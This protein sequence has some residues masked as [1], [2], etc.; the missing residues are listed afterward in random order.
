MTMLS[1]PVLPAARGP[2]SATVAA[3]LSAPPTGRPLV[4]DALA[5]AQPFGN[6]LQLALH[7]CYE[8]HYQ[9]TPA[10]TRRGSGIRTCSGPARHWST[11]S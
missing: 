4:L 5:G 1:S 10:S 2:L 7:L 9:G 6:D 11:S 3:A 8:Q